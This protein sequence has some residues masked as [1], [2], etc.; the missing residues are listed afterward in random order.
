MVSY[1]LP[2]GQLLHLGPLLVSNETDRLYQQKVRKYQ[3]AQ[4]RKRECGSSKREAS[5]LD[6]IS[7]DDTS[8]GPAASLPV[9]LKEGRIS[10]PQLQQ[11]HRPS[12]AFTEPLQAPLPLFYVRTEASPSR[13]SGHSFSVSKSHFLPCSPRIWL[14]EIQDTAL[15]FPDL[16]STGL[17]GTGWNPHVE[18][19]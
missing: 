6:S 18:K 7:G 14:P 1:G 11:P 9:P 4:S 13:V 5:A 12:G 19:V 15:V 10:I 2:Q 8:P 16:L 17:A 3:S